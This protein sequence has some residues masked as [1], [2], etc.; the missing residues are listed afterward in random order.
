LIFFF[1][2]VLEQEP[3]SAGS[4]AELLFPGGI[5]H[6]PQESSTVQPLRRLLLLELTL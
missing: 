5:L 1:E 6:A 4:K 3:G 2:L